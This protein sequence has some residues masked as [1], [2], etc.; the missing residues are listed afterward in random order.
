MAFTPLFV[1]SFPAFEVTALA[2]LFDD[3]GSMPAA[4]DLHPARVDIDMLSHG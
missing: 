2:T 3:A 1:M 4:L